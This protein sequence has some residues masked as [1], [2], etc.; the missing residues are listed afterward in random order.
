MTA[1]VIGIIFGLSVILAFGAGWTVQT[2]RALKVINP[3]QAELDEARKKI[4][5]YDTILENKRAGVPL[6]PPKTLWDE[7]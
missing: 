1:V 7:K 3:L 5:Y 6:N 2:A 4:A